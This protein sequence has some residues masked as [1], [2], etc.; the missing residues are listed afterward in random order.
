MQATSSCPRSPFRDTRFLRTLL[1]LAVPM[2]IQ[3]LLLSSVNML[4]SLMV[5]RLGDAEV[6]AVGIANQLYFVYVL[7]LE[8]ISG[9]CSI[10]IS[11]YWGANNRENIYKVMGLGFCAVC[12]MGVLFTGLGL[13]APTL[14]L[15][16]FSQEAPVLALG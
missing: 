14:V 3:K 7:F 16:L 1:I 10:F 13:L 6:A 11:Q 5:G 2:I 12:F 9:G 8:G 4:D 15:S